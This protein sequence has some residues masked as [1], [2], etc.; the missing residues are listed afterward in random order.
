[1][2]ALTMLLQQRKDVRVERDWGSLSD[3]YVWRLPCH[4]RQNATH[5]EQRHDQ[6]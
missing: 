2:A 4:T 1:M 5:R 6:P 3:R